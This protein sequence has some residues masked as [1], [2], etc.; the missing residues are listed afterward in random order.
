MKATIERV[1][2]ND[3]RELKAQLAQLK[4]ELAKRPTETK[5]KI[6]TVAD[7]RAI[8]RAVKAATAPL[9]KRLSDLRRAATPVINAISGLRNTFEEELP[10]VAPI[11]IPAPLPM[12]VGPFP[13]KAGA[14]DVFIPRSNG[15]SGSSELP[16]GEH[17][18]LRAIAQYPEGAQR[19][20]LTVL[21]GY[22]RSTRDAYIQRL[23]EKEFVV[24]NGSAVLATDTGIAALG[25]S[26]EPL[27]TGEALQEYWLNRL[28]EGERKIFAA[29][30]QT[31]S[32][33]S[34]ES[35]EEATGY[36]RSTRDAYIQR[37]QSRRLV[38]IVGRG[39]I[40]PSENLFA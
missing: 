40:R 36:K 11:H 12:K 4:K 30:L 1:K 29:L 28:P 15:H 8:E 38:E 13:A 22:K 7:P 25:S 14:R 31:P 5:T 37:L 35:L 19:D 21:T 27:P 33:L 24:E 9:L 3:P 39:E 16:K 18:I 34:R 2:E 17:I 23:R 26:Y 10:Q 20:Q 32:G 6:E